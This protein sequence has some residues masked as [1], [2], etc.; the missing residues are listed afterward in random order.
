[1]FLF[2]NEN[3]ALILFNKRRFSEAHE[4]EKWG[5]GFCGFTYNIYQFSCFTDQERIG[6]MGNLNPMFSLFFFN[7]FCDKFHDKTED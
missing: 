4:V 2:I 6:R 7:V 5:F 1:L 3:V